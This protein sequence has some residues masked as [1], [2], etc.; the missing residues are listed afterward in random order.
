MKGQNTMAQEEKYHIFF[1]LEG[2]E[3]NM[4]FDIIKEQGTD[5]IFDLNFVNAH[6]FGNIGPYVQ[7]EIAKEENDVVLAVYDVDDHKTTAFETVQTQLMDI[8]GTQKRVDAV[9]ICT[10]PNILQII[11]LG[12]DTLNNVTL[13]STSKESNTPIVHKYWN[14]IGKKR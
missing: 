3:E 12:C 8:L 2:D 7:D 14:D 9:S 11:L 13:T 4:L 6:G 5:P 1:V 10:N